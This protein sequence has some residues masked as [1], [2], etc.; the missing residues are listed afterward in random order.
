[1]P[2]WTTVA[3]SLLLVPS[4]S[5]L[6]AHAQAPV[7]WTSVREQEAA[8]DTYQRVADI[9]EAMRIRPGAV[10]ADIGAGDGFLTA[11]LARAVGPNGRV[12]AVDVD[13]GA[14]ERLRSRVQQESLTNV[15]VIRGDEDDPHLTPASLDAIVILNSYHEM[16]AHQAMLDHVRRALKSDGRLVIVEPLAEKRRHES[17][18]V[19]VRAH[20]M[21]VPF[22]EDDLRGA[23]FRV[24]RME[25]PFT[26]TGS[27]I[28]SLL[29]AVPDAYGRLDAV[30]SNSDSN[31]ASLSMA[32]GPEDELALLNGPALRIQ[33]DRFKQ[34]RDSGRVIV[35][36]V[37]TETEYRTSHIPEAI[38]VP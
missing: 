11:R 6:T 19:L 35:V 15:E 27:A 1:M 37:R 29:V 2:R 28:M 13:A 5:A 34:L 9:F 3:L 22:I 18:E 7:N 12:L 8:R 26:T 38:S 10:V 16:R 32:P 23:G 24:A 4:A 25:D 36:D 30:S 20:E 31:A 33:P 17:R 14:G 21:T